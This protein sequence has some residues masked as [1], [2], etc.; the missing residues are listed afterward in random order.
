MNSSRVC[1]INA[2]K[3]TA[4]VDDRPLRETAE[5]TTRSGGDLIGICRRPRRRRRRCNSR[6]RSSP[7]VGSHAFLSPGQHAF[8]PRGGIEMKNSRS[9]TGDDKETVEHAKSQ[10]PHRDEIPPWYGSGAVLNGQSS[11]PVQRFSKRVDRDL[12]LQWA[13][14]WVANAS[15]FSVIQD[16]CR[17][18]LLR[19]CFEG[20]RHL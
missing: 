11:V 13:T 19:E 16:H 20:G 10:R 15:K 5:L 14:H 17:A 1:H 18:E 9:V 7:P 3:R 8:G 2:N 4:P 12:D 6:Q